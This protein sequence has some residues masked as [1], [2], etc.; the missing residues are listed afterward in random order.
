[1][2]A[3]PVKWPVGPLSSSE[4]KFFSE[5]RRAWEKGPTPTREAGPTRKHRTRRW[6]ERVAESNRQ[7][8]DEMDKEVG[9]PPPEPACALLLAPRLPP[10]TAENTVGTDASPNSGGADQQRGDHVRPALGSKGGNS[11]S[12]RRR[13]R[14]QTLPLTPV[15]AKAAVLAAA[16]RAT[17]EWSQVEQLVLDFAETVEDQ[18][19]AGLAYR[20]A[21]DALD[22][23]QGVS[24]LDPVLAAA[25]LE[26]VA[27][28]GQRQDA[29]AKLHFVSANITVWSANILKWHRTDK[30]PLLVQELH[31]GD[32]EV[33]RLKVDALTQGYHL[34]VPPFQGARPTKGGVATLVP[35]QCQGRFR[36][37]Y[38]TEDGA[39]F[40]LVELPRV[41]HSL[42]LVNLYLRPGVGITGDPNAGVL[43]TLRPFLRQFPNWVVV[44]DWNFPAQELEG[45]SLPSTFRGCVLTTGE[46]TIS[47]GNCL[48]Y[49]LVSRKVASL[50]SAAVSWD[51]P[52]RPHAAV[53]YVFHSGGGQVPLPQL[54]VF[55]G[56]LRKTTDSREVAAPSSLEA[57]STTP[58]EQNEE[59]HGRG[60]GTFAGEPLPDTAANRRFA[61]LTGE[62]AQRH[63][64][65]PGGRGCT[66]PLVRRPLMQPAS[67]FP[68]HGQVAAWW[69]KVRQAWDPPRAG[70]AR[71]EALSASFPQI[72]LDSLR[73]QL[74][75]NGLPSWD[76]VAFACRPQATQEAADC[77]RAFVRSAC[78]RAIADARASE[79]LDYQAWLAGASVKGL[80]PL[81]RAVRRQEALV[82]RPFMSEPA[83]ARPFLRLRQ[84]A[85]LWDA[86]G[87]PSLPLPGLRDA[88]VQQA[89]TLPAITGA[90]FAKLIRKLPIKAAGMDGWSVEFLKTL[91]P[92]EVDALA[93]LWRGIEVTGDVPT[94]MTYTVFIMLAKT[95][96][97][98][99]PIGLMSTLLKLGMKARWRL[100]EQWLEDFKEELWWDC[101]LPSRST[102]DAALRRGF[103]Y[104]A[105]RVDKLHR[106]SLFLDLST[107]FER[108]GHEHLHDSAIRAGYPPL[109]L[110]LAVS[111]YRGGRIILSDEVASP[112]AFARRGIVAGCPQAPT[113]SKLALG[114]A[115]RSTCKGPDIQ[116]VGTWI[117]DISVDTEHS[118]PQR[119]ASSVVR[120]Y[121]RLHAALTAV[122]HQVSVG[123]TYFLASS[124]KAEKALKHQLGKDDPPVQSVAK[125]L[126]MQ[127]AGG[128][129]RC[130]QL[131]AARRL[132][133]NARLG[134]LRRLQVRDAKV[135]SRV[136]SLSVLASGIW[137]HQSQGVSPNTLRVVRA[138][139]AGVVGRVST[140]SVDVAL[141]LGAQL[142]KDPRVCIVTQHF[143]ALARVMVVTDPAQ[144]ARTW[145]QLNTQLSRDDRWRCVTG[146]L[147]AMIAY[148]KG[149]GIEAPSP[150]R[151]C[152]PRALCPAALAGAP[153][154]EELVA[155]NPLCRAH[156]QAIKAC[157]QAACV[158]Q[159]R[160]DISKQQGCA[161]LAGGVDLSVPKGLTGKAPMAKTA[162]LR[163]V[164]QG[165][166]KNRWIKA[167]A[168][169]PKCGVPLT[170]QHAL[171]DCS[172]WRGRVPPPPK[173]W[174]RLRA[175]YPY[176]CLWSRG[177]MPRAVTQ[178]SGY[179]HGSPSEQ[180]DGACS[181]S[182]WS[183]ELFYATDATGGP[184]AT[185][186]RGRV[187]AWAICAFT[188]EAGS[189]LQVG[190]LTGLLPP[191]STVE[192]G[193]SFAVASLRSLRGSRRLHYGLPG[194]PL[195]AGERA[196]A[197]ALGPGKGEGGM[198]QAHLD[199]VSYRCPG[200]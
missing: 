188:W 22:A 86:A 30:G 23:T 185:D 20:V 102:H 101:A 140:G 61:A 189:P 163:T 53:E 92:R 136:F 54:P 57:C 79:T 165:A 35:V 184:H 176:E 104:E 183:P 143:R 52:F 83:D 75:E 47:S 120:V 162:A 199:Q 69:Q 122:G 169:C 24:W 105:A 164:W 113:L 134:K 127:L 66:R 58:S 55:E 21:Y 89:L 62:L 130:T 36:G 19:E 68:W 51:V 99:R 6:R 156:W 155:L 14:W 200:S 151:W 167:G 197:L 71:F 168:H 93:S 178:L 87:S 181:A 125:D 29:E 78:D 110:H 97:I 41:R 187:I 67:G 186:P 139:A 65:K 80:K 198:G 124:R 82:A 190:Q 154:D 38:L 152:F 150:D 109:L 175:R 40:V 141:E 48:D 145:A 91:H 117:D 77:Q 74:E 180:A 133:A 103:S 132:K 4:K 8:W 116:F 174:E 5:S 192:E 147:G 153:V 137:G 138:Q 59:G 144:L 173:H 129:R 1:V 28:Q 170:H 9:A 37:G 15:A 160:L 135:T 3:W 46:A 177:L 33:R 27:A 106:C 31:M 118:G 26:D 32:E 161:S 146:P 72:A 50:L 148:L 49:A 94:Q 194:S 119:A 196:Q 182:T 179:S 171:Y 44:G 84:W 96:A 42:L 43:A 64:T 128:R 131:S 121:R 195:P 193:E 12:N 149:L 85:H 158:R 16:L 88:A 123:K 126:G 142:V 13:S 45:T 18:D 2:T 112:T 95:E 111:A 56:T 60:L 63:Y 39:G 98:E 76:P 11:G 100:V 7:F 107:F 115:I 70:L 81:F 25:F 159:R 34:F 73:S 191:G 108:V 17:P 90:Q 172:W 10:T 166:L 114:D 157:L